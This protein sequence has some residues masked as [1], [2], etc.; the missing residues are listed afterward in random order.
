MLKFFLLIVKLFKKPIELAGAD[1]P[2]LYA[3][4]ATK[5]MSDFRRV[6]ESSKNSSRNRS[7]GLQIAVYLVVGFLVGSMMIVFENRLMGI[8]LDYA[9]I[10]LILC[11]IIIVEFTQVIFDPKDNLILLPRPISNRTLMVSRLV[12]I[13]CYL[14]IISLSLSLPASIIVLVN[15]GLA[16]M[17]S[18]L[19]GV[20]T[21]TA[22]ALFA[23]NFIYMFLSRVISAE[24]FKDLLTYMQ[25]GL[26]VLLF[27]GIQLITR[28]PQ[29]LSLTDNIATKWWAYLVQPIWSAMLVDIAAGTTVTAAGVALSLMGIIVPLLGLLFMVRHL[30]KGYDSVLEKLATSDEKREDVGS[31]SNKKNRFRRLAC[32]TTTEEAGWKLAMI[33]SSRDRNF[34]QMVYPFIGFAFVYI[35]V[36]LKPDLSNF[37][38]SMEAMSHTKSYIGFIFMGVY[39]GSVFGM[40]R[41]SSSYQAAWIYKVT[42]L[43]QQGELL[44][45][46]IKAMLFKIF[47]PA[48]M[49]ISVLPV[50]LIWG[51][52]IIP[53]MALGGLLI[54]LIHL[55]V[56]LFFSYDL[57]F[58]TPPSDSG[59]G[60]SFVRMLAMMLFAALAFG[61]IYLLNLAGPIA[62]GA[63]CVLAIGVN[64]AM[65]I[66]IKKKKIA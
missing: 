25:V 2:Q 45:G 26:G 54:V 43:A 31:K 9:F 39:I 34:K 22:F 56:V 18:Y 33:I 66:C 1:Y 64:Y 15:F 61:V 48:Y 42:P 3:I 24:K 49:L 55:L 16:S 63:G 58:S 44:S 13:T 41:V 8:M 7:V 30:T 29:Y 57:P 12:H 35:F 32:H 37:A 20:F 62:F 28:L 36:I 51:S 14:S 10:L 38:A 27:G 50:C 21:T 19:L 60:T 40:I 6:P 59:R 46:A 65:F 4:V 17:L 5:L 47:L 11:S 52:S 23:S 53:V